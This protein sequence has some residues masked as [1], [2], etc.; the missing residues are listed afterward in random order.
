MIVTG[1]SIYSENSCPSVAPPT[2]TR[3]TQINI[4]PNATHSTEKR[5]TQINI[6]PSA[7][8]SNKTRSALINITPSATQ[9]N[10]IR[11]TQINTTPNATQSTK[12]E[13]LIETRVPLLLLPPHYK[14]NMIRLNESKGKVHSKKKGLTM[15]PS[16]MTP[17]SSFIAVNDNISDLN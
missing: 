15:I 1:K 17:L 11:S 10:K 3:N 14:H 13:V 8:Q 4:T 6:T 2:K 7:T 5:S 16:E 9:S 12:I